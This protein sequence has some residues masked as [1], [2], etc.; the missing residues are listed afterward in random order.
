VAGKASA[1]TDEALMVRAQDDDGLAFAELYGR[2][3]EDAHRIAGGICHDRGGAEE[4]V[5]DGFFSIWKS[6]ADY[7]PQRGSFKAWSM[8]IVRNRAIDSFRGAE[9][10]PRLAEGPPPAVRVAADAGTL[11]L[12]VA[13][14]GYERTRLFE[15]L[16]RLPDRQAEVILLAFYGDLSLS[17]IAIR[18]GI[19]TGTVKGRMRLGMEK[20]RLARQSGDWNRVNK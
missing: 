8:R 4:A 7:R 12:S 15:A 18:L 17:E 6:R 11:P 2:H 14:A 20:L 16:R 9:S 10:R 5:Q 3:A 19:P 1:V 13:V